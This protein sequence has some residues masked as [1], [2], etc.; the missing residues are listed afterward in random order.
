MRLSTEWSKSHRQDLARTLCCTT[1]LTVYL[2][3]FYLG[4]VMYLVKLVR[5]L[6]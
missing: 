1:D 6:T 3:L 2:F 5:Y 4:D